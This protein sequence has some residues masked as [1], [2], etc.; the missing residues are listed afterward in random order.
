MNESLG[1]PQFRS[2]EEEIAYLRERIAVRER[3]L[4]D[5]GPNVD[6]ADYATIAKS[7]LREYGE[8]SPDAVLHESRRL[9]PHVQ[10]GLAEQVKTSRNSVEEVL[11]IVEEHGIRNLLSAL[12]R[13]K[14]SF[15]VDEAHDALISYIKVGKRVANF[16]EGAPM[17]NVLHMT[18]FSVTLPE[19]AR[20]EEDGKQDLNSVASAMEQLYSG[21][22]T[23]GTLQ[24]VRSPEAHDDGQHRPKRADHETHS[25]GIDHPIQNGLCAHDAEGVGAG[26]PIGHRAGMGSQTQHQQGQPQP[27]RPADR[28]PAGRGQVT[29]GKEQE[30]ECHRQDLRRQPGPVAELVR[31]IEKQGRNGGRGNG[32][33]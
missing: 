30:D 2:P 31:Q 21:L 23:L 18:L 19:I 3:E 12:E 15:L 9:A 10:A 32:R 25:A 14:D 33:V 7:E 4:H 16:K 1:R 22:R 17:W 29:I 27:G 8:H 26:S 20:E 5:R 11:H 6:H 13:I 24:T 28:P